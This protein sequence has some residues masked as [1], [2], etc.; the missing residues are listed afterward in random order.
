MKYFR[1][2]VI[3]GVE[4]TFNLLVRGIT[5]IIMS[6][7]FFMYFVEFPV[8]ARQHFRSPQSKKH[9]G[10]ARSDSEGKS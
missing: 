7:L 6:V 4:Y 1:N 8:T 10:H 9:V 2:V 3:T 5:N